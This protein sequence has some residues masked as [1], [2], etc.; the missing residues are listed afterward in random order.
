MASPYLRGGTAFFKLDGNQH[1]VKGSWSYNLGLPKRDAIVGHD[2][3]HGFK[4]LPQQPFVEGVITDGADVD[5]AKLLKTDRATVT[6]E[7][8]NGKVI[9]LRDAWYAGEGT[10]TTE[11]GEIAVRFEGLSADEVV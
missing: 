5:L 4:E 11:E 1:R 3:V 10:V 2:G 6:L 8:A 7:L 9:T